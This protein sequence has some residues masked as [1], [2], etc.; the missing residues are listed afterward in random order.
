[1]TVASRCTPPRR[2]PSSALSSTS[3]TTFS[4]TKRENRSRTRSRSNATVTSCTDSA[5]AAPTIS[6]PSGYTNDITLP[7]SK[8]TCTATVNATANTSASA[9]VAA[10]PN[11]VLASGAA[12]PIST[13]S[14]T[15]S[16]AAEERSGRPLSTVSIALA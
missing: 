9:I 11:R 5:P 1:M 13:I 3:P 6:A 14:T 10:G 4:G 12:T 16:H 2:S 15:S 8:A 7:S